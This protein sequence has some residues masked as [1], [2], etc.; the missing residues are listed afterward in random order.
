[1]DFL[2]QLYGPVDAQSPQEDTAP[3]YPATQSASQEAPSSDGG[4]FLDELYGPVEANAPQA[5]PAK[6]Q[7]SWAKNAFV[8]GAYQGGVKQNIEAA[9]DAAEMAGVLSGTDTP[10]HVSDYLRNLS[11]QLDQSAAGKGME[12]QVPSLTDIHSLGDVGTFIGEQAGMGLGSSSPSIAAGLAA[13]AAASETGPGALVAGLG[14][15][16]GVSYLQ[17]APQV[18]RGLIDAGMTDKVLAAKA[19]LVAGAPM[20]ALDVVGEKIPLL[21]GLGADGIKTVQ[22]AI[23]KRIAAE[24]IKSG[25][26]EGTTEAMQQIIQDATTSLLTDKSLLTKQNLIG[27]ADNFAGGA[28]GGVATGG[29]AGVKK[30]QVEA[31]KTPEDKTQAADEPGEGSGA[32][33]DGGGQETGTSTP[34]ATGALTAPQPA[35]TPPGTGTP[36]AV[37]TPAGDKVDA[38]QA[39]ALSGA[40]VE[41]HDEEAFQGSDEDEEHG[42]EVPAVGVSPGYASRKQAQTDTLNEIAA[43]LAD[44]NAP[45]AHVAPDQSAAL[46]A[47][48]PAGT[49]HDASAQAVVDGIVQQARQNPIAPP[50]GSNSQVDPTA[51]ALSRPA[52]VQEAVAP[53][54][55]VAA[56]VATPVPA[57]GTTHPTG[58]PPP[59][60]A[61]VQAQQEAAPVEAAPAP[62]AGTVE[63]AQQPT[64]EEDQGG[65]LADVL[66]NAMYGESAPA[67]EQQGQVKDVS[68]GTEPSQDEALQA[69]PEV[70]QEHGAV[71]PATKPKITL[72]GKVQ[73]PGGP[74]DRSRVVKP[75][76]TAV[77]EGQVTPKSRS[78]GVAGIIRHD[79]RTAVAKAGHSERVAQQATE[80]A[81]KEHADEADSSQ[82]A[83]VR[84]AA[85]ALKEPIRARA[86]EIAKEI[87][88]R[89]ADESVRQQAAD[90]QAGIDR[91]KELDQKRRLE[92]TGQERSRA[93][94]VSGKGVE[95]YHNE[96]QQAWERRQQ[97]IARGPNPTERSKAVVAQLEK[98]ARQKGG[99]AKDPGRIALRKKVQAQ[100]DQ[101]RAEDLA[102]HKANVSAETGPG[103]NR[104]EAQAATETALRQTAEEREQAAEVARRRTHA[105]HDRKLAEVLAA[106][107]DPNYDR[108]PSSQFENI[109]RG[110]LMGI[111]RA[112]KA[113]VGMPEKISPKNSKAQNFLAQV[114]HIISKD[115]KGNPNVQLS[116]QA[117]YDMFYLHQVM[118]ASKPYEFY[119][120]L[121]NGVDQGAYGQSFDKDFR[122]EAEETSSLDQTEPDFNRIQPGEDLTDFVD[123]ADAMT[124][125]EW[126]HHGSAELTDHGIRSA[127]GE[128][129]VN[130][131]DVMSLEVALGTHGEPLQAG[132]D[133]AGWNWDNR[134]N[135][136]GEKRSV[137]GG[138]FGAI[139]RSVLKRIYKQLK[140][141]RVYF[142]TDDQ[143]NTLYPGKTD[144]DT[145]A[146]F[147]VEPS[148]AER[149]KGAKGTIVINK[150]LAVQK[151]LTAYT[152]QHEA[153]HGITVY[154]INHNIDGIRD[155]YDAMLASLQKTNPELFV[156]GGEFHQYGVTNV[157]ELVAEAF[158][159]PAFQDILA[160]LPLSDELQRRL[161][162]HKLQGREKKTWWDAFL[163]GIA[164]ILKLS[165]YRKAGT[166]YLDGIVKLSEA[167]LRGGDFVRE[168]A[169]AQV[170][171]GDE[172]IHRNR[173]GVQFRDPGDKY[174]HDTGVWDRF[175][176]SAPVGT[177]GPDML[178][179]QVRKAYQTHN[180]LSKVQGIG[181]RL[182]R[183][184]NYMKTATQIAQDINR[185]Y[186][187]RVSNPAW[188]IVDAIRKQGA[189]TKKM[190]EIGDE[191]VSRHMAMT[192]KDPAGSERMANLIYD[193]TTFE[194]D[195]SVPLSHANNAHISKNG[196]TDRNVRAAH[197]RMVAEYQQLSSEQQQLVRDTGQFFKKFQ[198]DM[199]TQTVKTMIDELAA[200][201]TMPTLPKGKT[202]QDLENFVLNGGIDRVGTV[203]ETPD[204]KAMYD[205]LGGLNA[206]F[207]M[208]T[209]LRM[210]RGYYSPLMRRGNY[211][212]RARL[213]LKAVAGAISHSKGFYIFRDVKD[214]RKYMDTHPAAL[215]KRPQSYWYD[216]KTG[217][218][219]PSTTQGAKKA[220][221][222]TPQLDSM[223][224][225][226]SERASIARFK[227][228]RKDADY[229]LVKPP[230]LKADLSE[231]AGREILP[232]T[233]K[234]MIKI[235]GQHF[236]NN[237]VLQGQIQQAMTTSI[238]QTMAHTRIQQRRL[239]RRGVLGYSKDIARA[240]ADFNI[241]AANHITR[242]RARPEIAAGFEGLEKTIVQKENR[243]ETDTMQLQELKDALQAHLKANDDY[244]PSSLGSRVVNGMLAVSFMNHLASTANWLVNSMQPG[245]VTLPRLAADHSPWAA[246]TQL[247]KAYM[248]IG[249]RQQWGLGFKNMLPRNVKRSHATVQP[250]IDRLKDPNEKD[251]IRYLQDEIGL[252]SHDAGQIG[253]IEAHD[254]RK[255]KLERGIGWGTEFASKIPQ[256]VENLN[257]VSSGLAAY[258]MGKAKGMTHEEALAY[259]GDVVNDTQGDYSNIVTPVM[260]KKPGMKLILQFKKYPQ[261]MG[262]TLYRNAYDAIH[263]LK[264]GAR[265]RAIKELAYLTITQTATAGLVGAPFME[266]P[267]ILGLI[268]QGLGL[269]DDD[270]EDSENKLQAAFAALMGRMG[271]P[272]A[273]K[274]SEM[275]FHGVSR[276]GGYGFD[277]SARMGFDSLFT[278]GSPKKND[279]EGNKAWLLDQLAGAPIGVFT[280]MAKGIA[281]YSSGETAKAFWTAPVPKQLLDIGKGI[282]GASGNRVKPSGVEI[283]GTKLSWSAAV[284]KALGFQPAQTAEEFEPGGS[285]YA[286]Q[287]KTKDQGKRTEMMKPYL[288]A[289]TPAAR[290]AAWQKIRDYNQTVDDPKL[291][292]TM[293]GLVKAKAKRAK[294]FVSAQRELEAQ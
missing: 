220:W 184:L 34:G 217:K 271:L 282:Y 173:S 290:D 237:P 224:M 203:R 244:D 138:V 65:S 28:V 160:A 285:G 131:K 287:L 93:G 82:H 39:A 251:L 261:M 102:E 229:E 275:L 48:S 243:S 3:A 213:K 130:P 153:V 270:W 54:P 201:G 199:T 87:E 55:V 155:V 182:R 144:S 21:R 202:V 99:N 218:A 121:M 226:D 109:A 80:Q 46:A 111:V 26:L 294:D 174:Y 281:A 252:V 189:T 17:N 197:G 100:L 84:A 288:T 44:P 221:I 124:I 13:G 16:A 205:A 207:K 11:T 140:G 180:E 247:G 10:Q 196:E 183:S 122:T 188:R 2:D 227:E 264:P 225:F 283:P 113:A 36:A 6:S 19:A 79:V 57:Q 66:F 71:A 85:Q 9:R 59:D 209:N 277:L 159:N 206:T 96:T 107:P 242:L 147:W 69:A 81:I 292:I 211:V 154:A 76:T 193:A 248:D 231:P 42:D 263:P 60:V 167:S 15:A 169:L 12:L 212:V 125:N 266:I 126:R 37:A 254:I 149:T 223:E 83:N 214:M 161:G 259:A 86:K 195:P 260:F 267:K 152:L 137:K 240:M 92:G 91:A 7:S 8:R 51:P 67:T 50:V 73:A 18:Y 162:D 27:W 142:V 139:R 120:D 30:D 38:S 246:F 216:P 256:V 45:S 181:S 127:N 200:K 56:P 5:V 94:K 31:P 179:Q 262:R 255:N 118:Q 165:G 269:T 253:G 64:Q 33:P 187:D 272:A 14:A 289:S 74:K 110:H 274:A 72:A 53:A 158:S 170:Y 234:K 135:K 134:L 123:R 280:N 172:G 279:E 249:P 78:E 168:H 235:A 191:L 239:K 132:A 175:D 77:E 63:P 103:I 192:R 145:T 40:P 150:S 232:A 108:L 186:K 284:W 4:G 164:S 58:E 129:T 23:Y 89:E 268:A 116:R 293:G 177:L 250:M 43:A 112:L 68:S 178:V 29:L 204:D 278:F 88:Q 136:S 190:M 265:S 75:T 119:K 70:K 128:V 20:A 90:I 273:M 97:T 222:V 291:K 35:Q 98:R 208:A 163:S 1:M 62:V 258:R 148:V 185:F 215:A 101:L 146:G 115:T 176:D 32:G 22:R 156:K 25:T 241:S 233:A 47:N 106:H 238:L 286:N 41:E 198:D 245:T 117:T 133:L 95:D 151:G 49:S 141:V 171:R 228:L 210:K 24:A 61:P 276:A 114:R 194:A 143:M 104:E 219:V 236:A 52:P 105:E 230:A 157:K 166:T 257:R